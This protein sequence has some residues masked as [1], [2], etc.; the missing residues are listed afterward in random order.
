MRTWERIRAQCK[1]RGEG[2]VTFMIQASVHLPS[3]GD[4][5]DPFTPE[6]PS[7]TSSLH[8]E[9]FSRNSC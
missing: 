2:E 6:S 5:R 8:I 4:G 1:L 3:Q 9:S 7:S